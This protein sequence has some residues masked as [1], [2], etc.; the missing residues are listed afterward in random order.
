MGDRTWNLESVTAYWDRVAD[1]YLELF[2][3]ELGGKPFDLRALAAFADRVGRG[4][5]V[6]DVGCGPCGHVTRYLADR[7]LEMIGVDV[8]PRCVALARRE[9][10]SL[11][12]EQMDMASLVF[13]DGT[14]DGVVAYYAIHY[15]PAA[16]LP[17]AIEEFFRVL[18]PG[19]E[20]L[21]VAKAGDGE[22]WIEDPLG[23]GE[24]VFW[25]A[26]GADE[27]AAAVAGGGFTVDRVEV[28]QPQADEIAAD[29]IY[30]AA[31]RPS[32]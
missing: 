25:A 16:A 30:V 2:R 20:L 8:S 24:P 32:R 3:D 4:G 13:P 31:S 5:R 12:F 17:A 21:V 6:C 1:R 7:G 14:M 27:L 10:P 15:Q 23:G 11:T 9:Q 19:G 18:R 29:R 22:G 28:R 26:F